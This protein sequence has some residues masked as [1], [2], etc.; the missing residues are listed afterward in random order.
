MSLP[1]SIV[2]PGTALLIMAA[3]CLRDSIPA[4]QAEWVKPI[5]SR[6]IWC[7]KRNLLCRKIF[8][9]SQGDNAM[10]T[11]A[12]IETMGADES[13]ELAVMLWDHAYEA[14]TTRPL[15]EEQKREL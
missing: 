1:V 2:S 11:K 9:R 10:L 4:S 15:T 12:E 7:G 5:S 3:P 14:A 6:S 13:I 8:G